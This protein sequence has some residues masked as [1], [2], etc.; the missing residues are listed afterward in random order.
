MSV[1]AMTKRNT[2]AA[3]VYS[4]LYKIV[5]VSVLSYTMAHTRRRPLVGVRYG[6][7]HWSC[8]VKVK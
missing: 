5:E 7:K 3:L 6:I 4:F 2:N 8:G 1:V